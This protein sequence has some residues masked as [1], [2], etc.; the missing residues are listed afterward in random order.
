VETFAAGINPT[1][2]RSIAGWKGQTTMDWDGG[3]WMM[4]ILV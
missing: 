1:D 3:L 2:T 4:F